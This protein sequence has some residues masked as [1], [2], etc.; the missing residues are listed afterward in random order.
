MAGMGRVEHATVEATSFTPIAHLALQVHPCLRR[1][2][3]WKLRNDPRYGD[4]RQQHLGPDDR[5]YGTERTP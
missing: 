4:N 5:P 3:S 1:Q 2:R